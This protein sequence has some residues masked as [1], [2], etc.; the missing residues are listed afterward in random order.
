[1]AHPTWSLSGSLH[2]SG[3]MR[4]FCQ[5]FNGI[6]L[7]PRRE[8]TVKGYCKLM[9]EV[10]H[11]SKSYAGSFVTFINFGLEQLGPSRSDDFSSVSEASGREVACAHADTASP[12]PELPHW[13]T[14]A[15]SS[16]RA[17]VL[18][19]LPP[20][21][22]LAAAWVQ[23]PATGELKP[24]QAAGSCICTASPRLPSV[25]LAAVQVQPETA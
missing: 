19:L 4:W 15:A 1:M 17:A 10:R 22:L 21:A 6:L 9:Q 3:G 5:D 23:L 20:S 2:F 16:Q 13:G 8:Q 11:W 7:F 18:I 12:S 14:S 25:A 24:S